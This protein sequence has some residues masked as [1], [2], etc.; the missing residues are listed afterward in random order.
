MF[1]FFKKPT[2]LAPSEAQ[3]EVAPDE[4]PRQ[5][6]ER[7]KMSRRAMLRSMGVMTGVA[8]V[9]LISSDD[10]A[11]LAVSKLRENEATR[12]IGDTLAK[13]FRGAGIAF[14][15]TPKPTQEITD[16]IIS[17]KGIEPGK[18]WPALGSCSDCG[19]ALESSDSRLN[20]AVLA[21]EAG[22]PGDFSFPDLRHI[23]CGGKAEDACLAHNSGIIAMNAYTR[24][25]MSGLAS[26]VV[27]ANVLNRLTNCLK[28]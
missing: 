9:T 23:D 19:N 3:S 28:A 27:I 12:E 20:I 14:A 6:F 25:M 5:R 4:T 2:S 11:R 16:V 17:C 7:E 24:C 8:V 26:D 1:K 21:V 13:E 10:L 22:L 18:P 15:A